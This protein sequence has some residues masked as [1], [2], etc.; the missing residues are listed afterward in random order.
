MKKN[1]SFYLLLSLFFLLALFTPERIYAMHI[2]EGYLPPG[3]CIFWSLVSLPFFILGILKIKQL[4]AD[5]QENLM[6]IGVGGAFSFVLSAL[7]LPSLTGSTSH[8]TGIGLGAILFGPFVMTV[9]GSI[10]LLFQALLLAHGGITTLGA[11]VFSMAVVGSLVAYGIY[12]GCKKLNISLKISVFLAASLGDLATYMVTSGQL[13][14]AFP[15]ANSGF[16]GAFTKFMS[17][18]AI[19]QIPLAIA[20]GI[21]TVL[22]IDILYK[23]NKENLHIFQKSNIR[24]GVN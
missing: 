8:A 1:L 22:I 5:H 4:I 14:L 20:E 19:T 24:K 18:F 10:V 15:D 6:L 13:A 7:K 16:I 11:N 21:L 23:Y 17:I 12:A 2:M 3:W 9:V